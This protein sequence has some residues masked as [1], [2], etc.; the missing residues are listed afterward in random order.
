MAGV[1]PSC[2]RSFKSFAGMRLHFRKAHPEAFH[3]GVATSREEIKKAR[4]DPE[5][6]HLMA[7]REV[8]LINQ[9][10]RFL[11]QALA[12]K[13]PGRS[14]EAIK[15]QRRQV[16]YRNKVLELRSGTTRPPP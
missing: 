7:V 10:C 14:L 9:G 11:N 3:E 12:D 2:H 4:W 1:C 13:V 6:I 15:G 16:A 8:E 5:E